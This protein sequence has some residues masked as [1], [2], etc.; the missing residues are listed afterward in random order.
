MLLNRVCK[1]KEK[2]APHSQQPSE[3]NNESAVE[4]VGASPTSSILEL[5]AVS[6]SIMDSL[7]VQNYHESAKLYLPWTLNNVLKLMN[8]QCDEPFEV[9]E[10]F[11]LLRVVGPRVDSKYTISILTIVSPG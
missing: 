6:D 4:P 11:S 9:Q 1:E 10:F 2:L 3:N 5:C 8:D 7:P